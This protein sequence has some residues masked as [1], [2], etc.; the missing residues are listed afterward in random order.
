MRARVGEL[1]SIVAAAT[2][3]DRPANTLTYSL[4]ASAP[5]VL[6][7]P[8]AQ[9]PQRV[10]TIVNALLPVNWLVRTRAN[11]LMSAELTELSGDSISSLLSLRR[12]IECE[13]TTNTISRYF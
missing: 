6:Y 5:A 11:P 1:F 10:S 13:F 7:V 12:I 3:A 9:V 8:A 4:D 2:D